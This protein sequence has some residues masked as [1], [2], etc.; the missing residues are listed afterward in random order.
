VAS[1]PVAID[2]HALPA[3][4]QAQRAPTPIVT[5]HRQRRIHPGG[6]FPDDPERRS[7]LRRAHHRYSGLDDARFF[8]RNLRQRRTQNAD[9]IDANRGDHRHHG[10]NDIGRIQPAAHADLEHPDVDLATFKVPHA[11]RGNAL[12]H[13]HER[14]AFQD[15][16]QRLNQRHQ[17]FFAD[18]CPVDANTLSKGVQVRGRVHPCPITCG[19][20]YR[21]DH[22]RRRAL[23]LGSRDVYGPIRAVRITQLMEEL[24]H[25]RQ[26]PIALGIRGATI[27]LII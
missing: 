26:A 3:L 24:F 23:A 22:R 19:T 25:S 15:G 18:E 4:C 1:V 16:Q 7:P 14:P 11:E 13:G 27:P 8:A 12:K 17:L 2:G 20:Q 10:H 9:M 6:H 21:L 5:C